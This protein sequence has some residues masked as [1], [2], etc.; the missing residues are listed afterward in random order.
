MTKF[1][2]EVIDAKGKQTSGVIEANNANDA[3]RL[4]KADGKY[5]S[6]IKADTGPSFLNSEIGSPKLKTKELVIISRQ[7][8]S[9]LAAGITIIRA[10]DML[11]QQVESK[12]AKA[13]VGSIYE[14]IQSGKTLS[15]AFKEQEKALPSIMITMVQAGEESGKLDEV[16]ARLAEHF[17][18]D[19]KIKNKVSSALVYPKILAFVAG[20]VTIGL[21]LFV[22]PALSETIKDLGGDLPALTKVV[23]SISKSLV[24]FWYIYAI[25]IAAI[26]FGFK[27]WLASE[28]GSLTWSKVKLNMPVVGKATKMTA[29]ARFTRTMSTLLRS[30][31]SVLQAV[32]ITSATM[33]NKILEK[34]FYEARI[35]IR[36]G[37]T[38]SKAIR[39][40][41]ELPPMIYAMVAIGEE[42]GTLDSILDKAADFFEDEADSATAKMTAALEPIMIIIM[43]LVVGLVVG[44][45]GMPVLN[46]AS[47]IT[48]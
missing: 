29:A 2:Y 19:A 32:E 16:M 9:L 7:L 44:A 40:I 23:M 27:T 18:K 5:I 31:I 22:V 34:K 1:K 26:V 30:G 8:A 15:E 11:Y 42:S 14:A 43:A 36:K 41:K 4:L 33:D 12:K 46:M 35:E 45:C 17:Q 25:F 13:C 48:F 37:T 10:L 38:L 28:S 47:F 6:S 20:A 39:P 24:R 21:M 3:A